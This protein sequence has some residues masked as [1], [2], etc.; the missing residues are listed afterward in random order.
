MTAI[1]LERI[2]ADYNK[3]IRELS[4]YCKKRKISKTMHDKMRDHAIDS[5]DPHGTLPFNEVTEQVIT[6][7][8]NITRRGQKRKK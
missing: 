1:S 4:I 3:A 6:N 2:Q 5:A 7:V 8:Y